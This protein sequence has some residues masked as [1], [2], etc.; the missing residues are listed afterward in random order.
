M[1]LLPVLEALPTDSNTQLISDITPGTQ[2][3]F[4][5]LIACESVEESDE[6][7]I[8]PKVEEC[9]DRNINPKDIVANYR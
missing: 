5:N 9:P 6:K 8:I 1:P 7:M 2:G 4:I 3:T